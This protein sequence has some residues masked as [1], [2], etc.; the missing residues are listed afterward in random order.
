MPNTIESSPFSGKNK[1]GFSTADILRRMN[2]IRLALDHKNMTGEIDHLIDQY[3]IANGLI[4]KAR[5]LITEKPHTTLDESAKM[6]G[7]LITGMKN[8]KSTT[9]VSITLE[10]ELSQ[11]EIQKNQVYDSLNRMK[12]TIQ[13]AREQ[14]EKIAKEIV[15]KIQSGE[16]KIEQVKGQA[17][18]IALSEQ[19]SAAKQKGEEILKKLTQSLS[20]QDKFTH[21]YQK[22]LKKCEESATPAIKNQVRTQVQPQTKN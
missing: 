9:A 19:L 20:V 22:L 2:D 11:L 14:M 17:S 5:N 3:S 21:E 10:G 13:D 4:A 6:I 7:A 12:V 8:E 18:L 15:N 16:I 1:F